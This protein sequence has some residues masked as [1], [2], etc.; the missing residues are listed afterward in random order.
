[1]KK[2]SLEKLASLEKARSDS[3]GGEKLPSQIV[4]EMKKI[5]ISDH[6]CDFILKSFHSLQ[7]AK[8]QDKPL[9]GEKMSAYMRNHKD[10][11][12]S[13]DLTVLLLSM[14]H[15]L[16]TLKGYTMR[17][18]QIA[19]L[20]LL[21]FDSEEKV[22]GRLLEVATGEGKSCVIACFAA[23]QALQGKKVD[24]VCSSPILAKRDEEEWGPFFE[25]FG[26]SCGSLP[27]KN[28]D[29]LRRVYKRDVVYATVNDFSADVL[30]EE[31]D[32]E[33]TRADRGFDSLIVDEV[34]HLTLDSCL[35]M[36]Y[37]SHQAPGM[38]HLSTVFAVIWQLVTAVVPLSEETK[39]FTKRPQFFTGFLAT[40]LQANEEEEIS[41]L[42]VL[43]LLVE[44][45]FISDEDY[46][47][48]LK[49]V[50]GIKVNEKDENANV[51]LLSDGVKAFQDLVLESVRQLNP[52]V[53][54]E[55]SIAEIFKCLGI[56]A[57]SFMLDEDNNL[58]M[59]E[60]NK[61]TDNKVI[62]FPNGHVSVL[63]EDQEAVAKAIRK[64]VLQT[65]DDISI[66][67][68]L[69]G[70]VE[71]MLPRFV[72]NA[73]HVAYGCELGS[74]YQIAS[75]ESSEDAIKT[76][77]DAVNTSGDA[78]IPV[79]VTSTG[80]LEKN[81]R[82]SEGV[83]QFLEMKHKLSVSDVTMTT[84]FL[85]NFMFYSRFKQIHGL[86]GTLG[87]HFDKDFLRER[88]G[89]VCVSVPSHKPSL[90]Q[91]RGFKVKPGEH[92]MDEIRL[93]IEAAV[94]KGQAALVICSDM[95]RAE[96]IH[97]LLKERPGQGQVPIKYW[98]D[99]IHSL[100]DSALKPK[101]VVISTALASRGTD[102]R[103][104]ESV[105]QNGGLHVLLTYLPKDS[106][107]QR[108]I[109]GRT[110][111]KGQQGS[112]S[113]ILSQDELIDFHTERKD[114]IEARRD[115]IEAN[116]VD[117][118]KSYLDVIIFQEDLFRTFCSELKYFSAENFSLLEQRK[119]FADLS[120]PLMKK[121]LEK[122][123]GKQLDFKPATDALKESWAIW[124]CQKQK[125][126]QQAALDGS[127]KKEEIRGELKAKIKGDIL[128]LTSGQWE[129][130]YHY[131]VHAM[132][133]SLLHETNSKVFGFDFVISAWSG[134]DVRVAKDKDR[135]YI[136]SAHYNLACF[137]LRQDAEGN[138][139]RALDL[140]KKAKTA[141]EQRMQDFLVD[142]KLKQSINSVGK[143]HV[144]VSKSEAA[145]NL[146]LQSDAS[147]IILENFL[148]NTTELISV[149]EN[150][151]EDT[152]L[153]V[154]DKDVR[155]LFDAGQ[156]PILSAE[157][158]Q[159]A[160]DGHYQCFDVKEEPKK[161]HWGGFWCFLLGVGQV[162]GGLA[163]CA[164]SAG[165]ASSI[166][167]NL[168]FEGI[169]DC[170]E[171]FK[172]MITGTFSWV[173]WAIGKAIS[174]AVSVLSFGVGK[175]CKW[176]K[177][178]G[179]LFK[180]C[181]SKVISGFTTQ[182]AKE[183]LKQALK[184]TAKQMAV[185]GAVALMDK[186]L[187]KLIEEATKEVAAKYKNEFRSS[188]LENSDLKEAIHNAVLAR[189]EMRTNS[190]FDITKHVLDSIKQ[191]VHFILVTPRMTI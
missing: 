118:L 143:S 45:E 101:D 68:F 189:A 21:M 31:F 50:E 17:F 130:F 127:E 123:A 175:A 40:L 54:P 2:I 79:D 151:N 29:D 140:L 51:S 53:E 16:K 142:A 93:D 10:L 33:P 7:H 184:Y 114:E 84:N 116:R 5:G 60:E 158:S 191:E 55:D 18:N 65:L 66:P 75:G 188:I 181:T 92:W 160:S 25:R 172:G 100:P 190:G 108:Q 122:M 145:P 41:E 81:K 119:D 103:L 98:R 183:S 9:A 135:R 150:R 134:L 1:M 61:E 70:F 26:L 47:A 8:G 30:K 43:A 38:H 162:L 166:G 139:E 109:V 36:T 76:S 63:Y 120:T 87:N 165:L 20:L 147:G 180:N 131:I 64:E 37:L 110:G 83:Q 117:G 82:Y 99:D 56:Q 42:D 105:N 46:K 178:G 71:K 144:E 185:Q 35:S 49:Q 77:G 12:D 90:T 132:G 4:G 11:K 146:V 187:E 57:N 126:I 174:L 156:D 78:I 113:L 62:I 24:V 107:T 121:L 73:I 173:Q 85:S 177:T 152:E 69:H 161:N 155:D 67:S 15:A 44:K 58:E 28:S 154:E 52:D 163:L 89:L 96:L 19:A 115:A 153:K 102:I 157:I 125:E 94:A 32:G 164:F 86:S 179:S 111:R 141:F 129:N 91:E 148:K 14:E 39:A 106:R 104:T 22:K 95:N 136:S 48:V 159:F 137:L 74:S 182:G 176:F 138:S 13:K 149:L 133:R 128:K 170:V 168:I 169:S 186:A 167:L 6:L 23:V 59:V 88:L 27:T 124:Y 34:D 80:I 97:D 112:Y 72:E 3:T 171:G